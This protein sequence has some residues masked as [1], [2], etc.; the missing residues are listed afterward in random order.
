MRLSDASH[1]IAHFNFQCI[2]HDLQRSQSNAQTA[3]FQPVQVRSIQAGVNSK[4]STGTAHSHQALPA[5]FSV[6]VS[7]WA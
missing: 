3:G 1:E 4:L 6:P 2:R 5:V 7:Y